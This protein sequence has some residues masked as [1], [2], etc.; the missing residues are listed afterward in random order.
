MA[1]MPYHM[2]FIGPRKIGTTSLHDLLTKRDL[3]LPQGTLGNTMSR[4][5]GCIAPVLC[6]CDGILGDDAS[7]RGTARMSRSG[8]IQPA[9]NNSDGNR[10]T[11]CA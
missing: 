7:E 2:F 6:F 1:K 8:S 3:P 9:E 4:R 11:V 5:R 10:I